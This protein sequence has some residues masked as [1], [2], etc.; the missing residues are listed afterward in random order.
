MSSDKIKIFLGDSLEKWH[1]ALLKSG[2]F[3]AV[4]D[5][6]GK[7]F[8]K[9]AAQDFMHAFGALSD[10]LNFDDRHKDMI[11]KALLHAHYLHTEQWRK[12]EGK[13]YISHILRVS[14]HFANWLSKHDAV[15]KSYDI[16]KIS[17]ALLACL[18]HDSVEDQADRLRKGADR[19]KALAVVEN[20]YGE[21]VRHYLHYLSKPK[22]DED[23]EKTKKYKEWIKYI[24]ESGD[25]LLIMIKFSD[26]Y[27][28]L[29][30][31]IDTFVSQD[32]SSLFSE[33][34]DAKQIEVMDKAEKW[35]MK[36]KGALE[37]LQEIQ[38]DG[39]DAY[40]GVYAKALKD[41]QDRAK[42]ILEEVERVLIIPRAK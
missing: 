17:Y 28:N 24:W 12:F 6:F 32:P 8:D 15:L 14:S 22:I 1:L 35:I 5:S 26:I 4:A 30:S 7:Y 16:D 36:Y 3:D 27:D 40:R 39:E 31:S 21:Q 9:R 29:R 11:L 2:D 33:S 13:P 38:S 42:D 37:A 34:F 25:T 41:A 23:D 20:Q 19:D 10:K 18:L